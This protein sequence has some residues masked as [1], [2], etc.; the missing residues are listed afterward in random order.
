LTEEIAGRIRAIREAATGAA[1]AIQQANAGIEG[2][3]GITGVVA[4]TV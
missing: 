4:T 2:T 3:S 1:Q